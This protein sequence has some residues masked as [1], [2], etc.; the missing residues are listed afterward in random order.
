MSLQKADRDYIPENKTGEIIGDSIIL[1]PLPSS[2]SSST[3]DSGQRDKT[4][5]EME[6]KP[7][8]IQQPTFATTNRDNRTLRKRTR[9]S[10]TAPRETRR[11]Q[12]GAAI[13]S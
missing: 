10:A 4:Q 5:R 3:T 12:G 13:G 2:S 7:E 9:K 8:K 1:P 6:Q 11:R